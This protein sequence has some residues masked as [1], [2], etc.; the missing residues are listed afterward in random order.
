MNPYRALKLLKPIRVDVIDR[1]Y[2]G[3][4]IKEPFTV[5][6]TVKNEVGSIGQLLSTMFKQTRPPDEVLVVDGGSTDGT[7]NVLESHS[8]IVRTI[9]TPDASPAAGRNIASREAKYDLQIT[10]DASCTL[11]KDLFANLL[12][13]MMEPD[14]P[15]I[16]GGIYEPFKRTPFSGY[17]IPNWKNT[18]YLIDGFLPSARCTAIHRDLVRRA[19]GFPEYLQQRWGE[20]TLF[21]VSARRLSKHWVFNRNAV[22]VWEAPTTL[23]EALLTSEHYG[24]GNAEGGLGEYMWYDTLVSGIKPKDPIMHSIF[25]GF[26]KG[27]S[28]RAKTEI[29]RRKI[30]DLQVIRSEFPFTDE[31]RSEH[32]KAVN[33]LQRG[34]KVIFIAPAGKNTPK[35]YDI[36]YTLL[37]LYEPEH[38][39]VADIEN[40][41]QT[42]N[43]NDAA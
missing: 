26:M 27:R 43:F 16:V 13:P 24:M 38:E 41:Y 15:D 31:S 1:T 6:M 12:G 37:E 18:A 14:P 36:D 29:E 5:C 10:L 7:L 4:D 21:D 8:H 28:L 32:V 3:H 17:F 23:H 25:T 34:S 2:D 9:A 20:D 35:Y 30:P 39:E 19:G 11:P 33:A 42:G 22:V 40:R